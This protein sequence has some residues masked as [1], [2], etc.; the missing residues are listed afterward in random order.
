MPAFPSAA[1][2]LLT[3]PA[4]SNRR[5][6]A[7]A[8]QISLKEAIAQVRQGH[9][10]LNVQA[11][12]PKTG[13]DFVQSV[14]RR[15]LSYEEA[16]WQELLKLAS[17]MGANW[18][19]KA[20]D[21]LTALEWAVN[22]NSWDVARFLET[23]G[24]A[25]NATET[26]AQ[27][28]IRE[29]LRQ[30][31]ERPSYMGASG[32]VREIVEAYG[33]LDAHT[34]EGIPLGA[35]PFWKSMSINGATLI[36]MRDTEE[37]TSGELDRK[38][39]GLRDLG[40]EANKTTPA[41]AFSLWCWAALSQSITWLP[42]SLEHKK[43]TYQAYCQTLERELLRAYRGRPSPETCLSKA[44]KDEL[45]D[46][47]IRL[48]DYKKSQ[49]MCAFGLGALSE[50]ARRLEKAN[51]PAAFEVKR[52]AW[53][54]LAEL[55]QALPLA[56]FEKE[57]VAENWRSAAYYLFR[58]DVLPALEKGSPLPDFVCDPWATIPVVLIAR[59][60]MP[61][62]EKAMEWM[63]PSWTQVGPPGLEKLNALMAPVPTLWSHIKAKRLEQSFS[64]VEPSSSRGVRL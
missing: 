20:P 3:E 19:H 50:W 38:M 54:A 58:N 51:H 35:L 6:G 23:L 31:L 57:S 5:M 55:T 30:W 40:R 44:W 33:G 25:P 7:S 63:E 10:E 41:S 32:T 11:I 22:Q 14:V 47:V 16:H 53:A 29:V 52:E 56:W 26:V 28:S 48:Q 64:T 49:P 4:I 46:T 42:H 8:E 39:K 12:N 34:K 24:A 9:W 27:K 15:S 59:T 17:E 1:F 61:L 37:R 60:D 36:S 43:E 21:G 62:L 18:S 45:L 13:W 2:F